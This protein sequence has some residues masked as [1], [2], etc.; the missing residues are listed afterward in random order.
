M[1]GLVFTDPCPLKR[2][3]KYYITYGNSFCGTSFYVYYAYAN[4]CPRLVAIDTHRITLLDD[5]QTCH[6][7]VNYIC[8]FQVLIE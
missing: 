6:Q 2:V 1:L 5:E 4:P 8:L 7:P 3:K